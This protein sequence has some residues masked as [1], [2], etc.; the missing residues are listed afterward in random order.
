MSR[1]RSWGG[2]EN[3]VGTRLVERDTRG[4][5]SCR[6]LLPFLSLSL[7]LSVKSKSKSA[8][9][10]WALKAHRE[11]NERMRQGETLH[12][13]IPSENERETLATESS[14]PTFPL[15]LA[16]LHPRGP[17]AAHECIVHMLAPYHLSFSFSHLSPAPHLNI[18]V[19]RHSTVLQPFAIY[20]SIPF[21]RHHYTYIFLPLSYSRFTLSSSTFTPFSIFFHETFE[22]SRSSTDSNA[23]LC[24]DVAPNWFFFL[25]VLI[26]RKLCLVIHF[27][28]R[29]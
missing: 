26:V 22:Y 6:S 13:W 21:H 23:L 9:T 28:S 18:L 8:H 14:L 7:F 1:K 4:L 2:Y 16:R 20:F 3:D 10:L 19:R 5:Y 17:D 29:F 24:T 25:N 27:F 12:L 15:T 11:R